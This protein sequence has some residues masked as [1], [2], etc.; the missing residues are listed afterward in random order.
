MLFDP[1][2]E[3][4]ARIISRLGGER[5]GWLT[6]VFPDGRPASSLI[7]FLWREGEL[8]VYSQDT[9]RVTNIE[10]HPAVCFNLNSNDEGGDVLVINGDAVVDRSQPRC[11]DIPEYLAKYASAMRS[12]GLTPQKFA[13]RYHVPIRIT[14]RSFRA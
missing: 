10:S 8:L 5:L 6:T 14:P 13:D 9:P 1:S 2:N 3:K 11:D 7:W 12:L 4:H